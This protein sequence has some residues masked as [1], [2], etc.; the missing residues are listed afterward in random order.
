[1]K[2]TFSAHCLKKSHEK[3]F[4]SPLPQEIAR[5]KLFQPIVSDNE[6]PR[7]EKEPIDPLNR[8]LSI[9][10]ARITGAFSHTHRYEIRSKPV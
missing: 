5:K 1:M 9:I 2:K 8:L 10:W 4:F 7:N 3:N 6:E